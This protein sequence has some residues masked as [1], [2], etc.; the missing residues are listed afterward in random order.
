MI[1]CGP[2]H[3][4]HAKLVEESQSLEVAS[5]YYLHHIS[6]QFYRPMHGILND[7]EIERFPLAA[8]VAFDL[9]LEVCLDLIAIF[10]GI[11]G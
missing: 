10:F 11:L 8:R 4:A 7:C 2:R 9:A 5:V 3:M 1:P 6:W